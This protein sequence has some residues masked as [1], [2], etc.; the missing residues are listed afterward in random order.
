MH[1][2]QP[3]PS[4]NVPSYT[5]PSVAQSVL[6]VGHPKAMEEELKMTTPVIGFGSIMGFTADLECVVSDYHG[7]E[8]KPHSPLA[9]TCKFD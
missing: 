5:S 4:F 3:G 8:S 7:G 2:G 9:A 6:F 1:T